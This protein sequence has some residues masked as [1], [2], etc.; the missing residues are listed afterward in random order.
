MVRPQGLA[1]N[2]QKSPSGDVTCHTLH[3]EKGL[4][5]EVLFVHM[6]DWC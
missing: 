2:N 4:S 6:R 3:V 1:S 5:N